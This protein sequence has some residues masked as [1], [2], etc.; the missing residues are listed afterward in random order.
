M[1]KSIQF[2][3][4]LSFVFG[5]SQQKTFTIQWEGTKEMAT[6]ISRLEIP[7]FNNGFSF[8]PES[9][10]KFVA[11]WSSREVNSNS[12][13][14]SNVAYATLTQSD[15][16]D[17][18]IKS[19]PSKLIYKLQNSSGRDKNYAFL[20]LSPI[21]R[22]GNTYKKVT[23]FTIQYNTGVTAK[24]TLSPQDISNSVLS[25]GSWYKFYVDKTGVFKLTKSFL[26]SLGVNLN[27]IDP[28]TIKIYGN[29]GAML[30]YDNSEEYPL[31]LEENAIK[32]VGEEDGVFNNEDYILFY[33][34]GPTGYNSI[35][36]TNNNIYTDRSYYF[37]NISPGLGKRILPLNQ[38][39][40]TPDLVLDTFQDYQFHEVDDYNLAKMGRRWFGDVFDVDPSKT[41]EFDFPNLVSSEPII[42]KV[43]AAAVAEAPTNMQISVNGSAIGTLNFGGISG[44]ILAAE[45][46][47]FNLINVSS[48][49]I[50][51]G[52]DYNNNGDP[53]ALGY[54]DYISIEATRDLTYNGVQLLFKNKTTSG[55]TG[56]V[57]YNLN[58]TSNV[59]EIW[60]VSDK[61]NVTNIINENSESSFSFFDNLGVTKTYLAIDS[62]SLYTP[63]SDN[64]S[65]V[66]NQNIKGTI[67]LN[68]QGQFQDVDYII[69][70]PNIFLSQAERLAQINRNQ[71]N[72]NVK[73]LTLEKIY[74]EFSSGNQDVS[75]I[76]NLV[77][78]VYDNASV[79]ENRIKYL[80]LFGDA[81]FDYKDR[82]NGNTNY[83]PSWHAYS[84]FNLTNSF[85]SDDFFG[86]M[87]NNEGNMSNYNRLDI[88]VGRILAD[89]P[90]KANQL[91]D[92]IER[93]YSADAFGSWRN[94]VLVISDDVD[95]AWENVL[96]Q[97]TNNI[98][99][100]L[101]QEKP[102]INV[103]KIH[104]DS[105]QQES[106]SAGDRYPA[107][108]EAISDALEL[109]ALV[110]NYFGHGGED[111][112]AKE[113]FFETPNI[114]NL[115]NVCKLNCFVTVTCE[116][117]KFDNPLRETAGEFVYWNPNGGAISLITTTRQIF[118]PV[119]T[120]FNNTL[121]QY[122]FSYGSN[123]Y[124][125][126]AE[127]L[128][129]TKTNPSVSSTEQRRLVFFIG[130]PAMKLTFAKPNIKLT[131]INDVPITQPSDTLKALSKV[132]L[133]GVVTDESDTVLTNYN[134]ILSTT[135]YDKDIQRQTLGND[136]TSDSNGQIIMD[137]NTSGEIIFRGQ[138]TVTNGE[139][140]FEFIV[141]R[142]I[143]IPVGN[144][145]VSFYSK[146]KDANQDNAG[147]NFDVK[148]GGLN[149]N[150]PEDNL[151]PTINLYLNDESFVSGGVTN[152]DP[153]LIAVLEDEN[154]INTASGIGHDIVAI[155]DNDETNPFVL[156]NY[157]E[158]DLD[159]Y[160]KG[161][162][163][164][165]FRD[166]EPGLHTMTLKAWD[167]YNNSSTAEIQFVVHDKDQE[168]R[169]DNVLN[170]PNPFVN[171]TEFWFNHN[172]SEPLDVSIQIFTVSG[173]LVRTINS[174]TG[175]E[176]CCD[177]GGSGLS[178]SIAWDGRDDF[179]DKIGKGVYV[180]KLSV[181][182]PS[183]N[184]TV[185]KFEKLVIL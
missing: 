53:S 98:G 60:D 40:G 168:L 85:V 96:Q 91:V 138:A 101:I 82:I 115:R 67:F 71:Y 31:D 86:M 83:V 140:D 148:I 122:L 105:Y 22:E 37:L 133:A 136:G 39:T 70:T 46:S 50:N 66:E 184:K 14:I 173:K 90:Q 95:E 56:I 41:F 124:P 20:E 117:T 17:L 149:L 181:K 54:L 113:R 77:K 75:A 166:L 68:E 61:Y 3:I 126:I 93:Y 55:L 62:S 38:P 100:L 69:V 169:I 167:V 155:I 170:Y 171:Y 32:F 88:A 5:V 84:S 48:S 81:S 146:T 43:F 143:S 175:S 172:S 65:Y 106:S 74:L 147:A 34:E 89:S 44:Q 87:D 4:L 59:T 19:I 104:S 137:F 157:Y 47:F 183:L 161:T 156:N 185:E 28:R 15:L 132:K 153:T 94:N 165:P 52:L 129:L 63:L 57:Q 176:N 125:S 36:N 24:T 16:K 45:S 121:D 145:K 120:A 49:T 123:Q 128:R 174:Q 6:E 11:Q 23:S 141:P 159:V 29:G 10:L 179:G 119:A 177:L 103:T 1:K 79:P 64:N 118:V 139:F 144:G 135:I 110:V 102:F 26:N 51:V 92:K 73:V 182:S 163:N 130:D 160:T 112:L 25:A 12:I 33:A 162:V 127:A 13:K 151:G 109:G 58:N 154:G 116:F 158:T 8:S 18:D 97:T 164:Y 134:G 111:G 35:S 114:N 99:D 30:P 27:N 80:C 7:F 107:V 178:R 42:L 150:A 108:T 72:I 152:E 131:A 78:Y 9:G 21:I 76:R 142:D 180:Y 2:L